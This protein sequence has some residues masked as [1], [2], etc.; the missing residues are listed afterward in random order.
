MEMSAVVASEGG[1]AI[2]VSVA[3]SVLAGIA[4]GDAICVAATGER[5]QGPDHA[6]A[7]VVLR[8]VDRRMGDTLRKLVVL[9]GPS[10]YGSELLSAAQCEAA[11]RWAAVLVDEATHRTS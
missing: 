3:L 1:T 2:N 7:A 10:H 8:R 6:A 4:A 5:Y 11:M 9:K